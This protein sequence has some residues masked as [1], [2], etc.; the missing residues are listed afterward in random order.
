MRKEGEAREK[1]LKKKH[2]LPCYRG[3]NV[4]NKKEN[5]VNRHISRVEM[6][7]KNS[8]AILERKKTQERSTFIVSINKHRET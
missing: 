1:C 4:S 2:I 3:G 5:V 6:L 7:K 8:D